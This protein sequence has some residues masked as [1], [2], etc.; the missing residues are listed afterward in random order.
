MSIVYMCMYTALMM[1]DIMIQRGNDMLRIDDA[2]YLASQLTPQPQ[3]PPSL[4][5]GL[6][7]I[8]N[9]DPMSSVA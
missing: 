8:R 4:A 2:A 6:F 9:A 5:C 3:A 7:S 1:I